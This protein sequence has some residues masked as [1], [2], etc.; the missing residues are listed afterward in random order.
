MRPPLPAL[1]KAGRL[2]LGAPEAGQRQIREKMPV[3]MAVVA[4]FF[5]PEVNPVSARQLL[6]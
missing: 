4:G 6:C 1:K 5:K 3:K 2:R